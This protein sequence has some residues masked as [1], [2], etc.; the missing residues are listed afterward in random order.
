MPA[1]PGSMIV[2]SDAAAIQS[3][4]RAALVNVG[5][6]AGNPSPRAPTSESTPS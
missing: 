2:L 6:S 4:P 1:F 5:Q 3:R